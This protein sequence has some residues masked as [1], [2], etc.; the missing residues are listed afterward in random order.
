MMRVQNDLQQVCETNLQ[1]SLH[2]FV[3]WKRLCNC[4]RYNVILEQNKQKPQKVYCIF[5]K[6]VN[7]LKDLIIRQGAIPPCL[8]AGHPYG[9]G[10]N[11]QRNAASGSCLG[12]KKR[13]ACLPRRE[14]FS[15]YIY[16]IKCPFDDI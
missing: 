12:M 13:Q 7:I 10:K 6:S 15:Y 8:Q 14:C 16:H 1:K 5:V 3:S 9:D 11:K 2:P 4:C